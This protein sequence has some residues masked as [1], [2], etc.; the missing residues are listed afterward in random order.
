MTFIDYIVKHTKKQAGVS[1]IYKCKITGLSF[2]WEDSNMHFN[3][4]IK[5]N[6]I[7]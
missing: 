3:Y 2:S 1:S 6:L 5:N 4:L 7:K